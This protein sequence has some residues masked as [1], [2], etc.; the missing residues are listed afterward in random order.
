MQKAGFPFSVFFCYSS[1]VLLSKVVW[2]CFP[3]CSTTKPQVKEVTTFNLEEKGK[4]AWKTLCRQETRN[5][6]LS[7]HVCL[8]IIILLLIRATCLEVALFIPFPF[9]LTALAFLMVVF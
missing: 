3:P 8:N 6:S 4:C 7:S 9:P 1:V 5:V 2:E